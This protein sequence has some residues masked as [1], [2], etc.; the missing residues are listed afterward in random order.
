[1]GLIYTLG[2]S[3]VNYRL[4]AEEAQTSPKQPNAAAHAGRP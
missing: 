1:L 4:Y 2:R 3:G